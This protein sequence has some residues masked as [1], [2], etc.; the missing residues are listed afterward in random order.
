MAPELRN[1]HRAA[2]G[3][4][5]FLGR[6]VA[7]MVTC[8]LVVVGVMFSVAVL[9]LAAVAGAMLLG[10][11]WWKTRQIRRQMRRSDDRSTPGPRGSVIE[12]EVLKG[13]WKDDQRP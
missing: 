3:G 4:T 8:A 10:W 6:I 13:E 5:G 12:G 7:T 9:A 11:M 2:G 1:P